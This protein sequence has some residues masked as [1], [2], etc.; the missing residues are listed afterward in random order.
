M[1]NINLL[2]ENKEWV[3]TGRNYEHLLKQQLT[4]YKEQAVKYW[5]SDKL[6]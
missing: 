4:E 1:K 3:F 5:K 2:K 6:N